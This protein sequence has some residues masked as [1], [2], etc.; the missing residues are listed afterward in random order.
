MSTSFSLHLASLLHFFVITVIHYS[1]S[2]VEG[3]KIVV[4]Q[5]DRYI[6]DEQKQQQQQQ[7]NLLPTP[8]TVLFQQ[9]QVDDDDIGNQPRLFY[10]TIVD[11]GGVPKV[12]KDVEE[13]KFQCGISS[14]DPPPP[15]I[16]LRRRSL[17]ATAEAAWP[18]DHQSYK[19]IFYYNE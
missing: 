18:T 4:H 6:I 8:P 12:S 7:L 14:W 19:V 15:S 5:R 1:S 13:E 3:F 9:V 2:S 16:L 11:N 10:T 17:S